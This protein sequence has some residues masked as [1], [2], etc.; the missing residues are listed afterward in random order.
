MDEIG[1]SIAFL[2]SACSCYRCHLF[3]S[4]SPAHFRNL[5]KRPRTLTV[6]NAKLARD[7]PC[8]LA[9]G[10]LCSYMCGCP[11]HSRISDPYTSIPAVQRS[12]H[13]G[14]L[15]VEVAPYK[16][17]L[18]GRQ[19]KAW[20][21]NHDLYHFWQHL[22]YLWPRRTPHRLPRPTRPGFSAGVLRALT[23]SS[24]VGEGG[25]DIHC[26]FSD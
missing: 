9:K 26:P 11:S 7:I 19:S 5:L 18:C 20:G 23:L 10:S 16:W 15:G 21:E 4:G 14:L 22:Y 13:A 25:G 12:Q 6:N 2:H 24:F 3:T 8:R 1:T 17:T